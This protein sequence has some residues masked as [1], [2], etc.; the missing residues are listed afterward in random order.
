ML[1]TAT[2]EVTAKVICS[3][4]LRVENGMRWRGVVGVEKE[5]ERRGRDGGNESV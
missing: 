4:E 3:R 1:M 5:E 2:Q